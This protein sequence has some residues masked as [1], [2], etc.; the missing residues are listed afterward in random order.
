MMRY[1]PPKGTAGLARS[2][3]SGYRRLPLPPAR[4]NATTGRCMLKPFLMT[5]GHSRIILIVGVALPRATSLR[6]HFSAAA[7][8]ELV[9][10]HFHLEL[11]RPVRRFRVALTDVV[12]CGDMDRRMLSIRGISPEF[13]IWTSGLRSYA[14]PV[15]TARRR[16]IITVMGLN[17][18]K[19]PT[20]RKRI[21]C[22]RRCAF[23]GRM[24]GRTP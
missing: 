22:P 10:E 3:V 17:F 9:C 7:L 20:M 24:A 15:P 18:G 16:N 13:P 8:S 1:L 5:R 21:R 23:R 2:C 19:I 11:G 4:T 6:P 12:L 14:S